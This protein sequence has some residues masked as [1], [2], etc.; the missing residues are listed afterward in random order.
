MRNN[1]ARLIF[2]A[3][4]KET[5]MT[6]ARSFCMKTLLILLAAFGA[7]SFYGAVVE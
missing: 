2:A 4:T 1:F 6:S 3:D 5:R 7:I